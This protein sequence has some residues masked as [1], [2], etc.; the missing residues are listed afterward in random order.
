MKEINLR[1]RGDGD[2]SSVGGC[3]SMDSL[4]ENGFLIKMSYVKCKEIMKLERC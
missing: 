3:G 4:C 2:D 1:V